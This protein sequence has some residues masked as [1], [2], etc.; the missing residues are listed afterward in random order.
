V[1]GVSRVSEL[2][3]VGDLPDLNCEPSL[4]ADLAAFFADSMMVMRLF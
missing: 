4:V 3:L 2:H 1:E